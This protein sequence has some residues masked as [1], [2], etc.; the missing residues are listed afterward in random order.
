MKIPNTLEKFYSKVI[1][2]FLL[3]KESR[4]DIIEKFHK[5]FYEDPNTWRTTYWL[6]QLLY[7]YPLDLWIYQ[8]IIYEQKPDI[9]IETGT[10]HGGSALFLANICDLINRGKVITIDIESLEDIPN[11]KRIIYLKGSSTSKEIEEQLKQLIDKNDNVMVILDSDHS[12]GHVLNELRVYHKFVSLG[13]YLIVED[14]NLNG[15][16][17]RKEFGPGPMEAIK[18]FI[19]ENESFKIDKSKEK[20]F[21]TQNPNGFLKKVKF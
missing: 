5:I 6:G 16:P 2:K 9:I 15:H 10:F 11:H 19:R 1:N 4:K 7:K 3:R 8:Q 20:Y 13:Y 18:E 21:M 14:S 12:K 17:I